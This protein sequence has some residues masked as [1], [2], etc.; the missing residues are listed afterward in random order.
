MR[1]ARMASDKASPGNASP[2]PN[3]CTAAAIA[4]WKVVDRGVRRRTYSSRSTLPVVAL[5]MNAGDLT[6]RECVTGC[7]ATI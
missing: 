7:V 1:P 5:R 6:F 2:A 3:S 4:R